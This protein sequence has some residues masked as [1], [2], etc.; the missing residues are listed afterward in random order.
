MRDARKAGPAAAAERPA[1]FRFG[2]FGF[3]TSRGGRRLLLHRVAFARISPVLKLG[4]SAPKRGAAPRTHQRLSHKA[5][6]K[7]HQ[8]PS[9][10]KRPQPRP[11]VVVLGPVGLLAGRQLRDGVLAGRALLRGAAVV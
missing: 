1:A 3:N 6:P 10:S 5:H 8:R 7:A 2:R 11:N 9:R 4:T